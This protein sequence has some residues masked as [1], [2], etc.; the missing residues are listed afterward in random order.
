MRPRLGSTIADLSAHATA[1]P[2]RWT[3]RVGV[4][5]RA[6]DKTPRPR[7]A[8]GLSSPAGICVERCDGRA[9]PVAFRPPPSYVPKAAPSTG[10]RDENGRRQVSRDTPA[11]RWGP[12]QL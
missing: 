4:T 2:S 11:R 8:I 9:K 12:T 1:D 7:N 5:G 6:R 10:G 3:H